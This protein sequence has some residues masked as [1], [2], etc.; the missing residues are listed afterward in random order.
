MVTVL[1]I[2]DEHPFE[3]RFFHLHIWCIEKQIQKLTLKC[4]GQ[5]SQ[6]RNEEEVVVG[7][8]EKGQVKHCLFHFSTSC[9]QVI[10]SLKVDGFFL[11]RKGN[12][13]V[14]ISKTV[15]NR[16]KGENKCMIWDRD[17]VVGPDRF[18]PAKRSQPKQVLF[19]N[20]NPP[21]FLKHCVHALQNLIKTH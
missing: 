12:L 5:I 9:M 18:K 3:N 8:E 6:I 19:T 1:F 2:E 7:E 10:Q 4:S 14:N 16:L 11:L 15:M 17:S 13:L 21:K 20:G